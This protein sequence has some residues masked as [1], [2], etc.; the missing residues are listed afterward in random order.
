M[1]DKQIIELYFQRND[2][3]ILETQEK[4][5]GYVYSIAY[6]VLGSRE[7]TQECVWDVYLRLWN[8]IP[9]TRPVN[10]KNFLGRVT[11]NLALDRF[12]QQSSRKCSVFTEIMEEFQIPVLEEPGDALER[13][14]LASAISAFIRSQPPVKQ[15]IFLLR[16][17]Y[18]ESIKT[19]SL[20]TGL[21]ENRIKTELYRMRK[22]LKVF[23]EREGYDL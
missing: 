4:Y 11:H 2:D 12:R 3:A 15:K 18:Y 1:D 20:E 5:A 7:D 23:L 8:A 14:E 6:N 10:L 21:K 17:W 9:P 19:I 16:Y 13:K 22:K